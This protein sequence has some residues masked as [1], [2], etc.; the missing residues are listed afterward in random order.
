MPK[1][2]FKIDATSKSLGRIAAEAASIL[3]GKNSTEFLP[4]KI[5]DNRV[6]VFNV[7][8]MRITG[9]KIKDKKYIRYSGYPGGVKII[10]LEEVLKKDPN[11]PLRTAVYGML[12]KNKLRDKLIK[13]LKLYGGEQKN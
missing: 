2:I 7:L 12:P 11:K 8:K 3:R 6:V 13:N 9:K 10:S 5:S 1:N 4:N